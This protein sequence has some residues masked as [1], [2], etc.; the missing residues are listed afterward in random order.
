[1]HSSLSFFFSSLGIIDKWGGESLSG[2]W[3]GKQW[4]VGLPADRWDSG[5]CPSSQPLPLWLE[6]PL[7]D[8]HITP[9]PLPI[10]LPAQSAWHL[11]TGQKKQD[12]YN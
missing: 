5:S 1:M 2:A 12:G 6:K 3:V 11:D 7:R 8:D 9:H 10:L 4:V